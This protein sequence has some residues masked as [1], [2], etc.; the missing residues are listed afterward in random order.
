MGLVIRQSISNSIIS[1]AGVAIGYVNLLYLYP[2]ILEPEQIGTLRTL[3]D[4]ALLFSPFAQFGV[5]QSIQR[6]FPQFGKDT[7]ASGSFISLML[8]MALAG[9]GLFFLAFLACRQ[10]AIAYFEPNAGDFV[11]YLPLTLWLT[12]I[13]VMT[14]VLES[15][16]RALLKTVV[17][18]LLRELVVR[19]LLGVFVL[20]YFNGYLTFDQF[21]LS[22]L[23]AYLICLVSLIIYLL[24]T[25]YFRLSLQ[26]PKLESSL[27]KEMLRYSLFGFAGT[28]G[29]IIIGKV[30][31]LMVAGLMGLAANAVY[32][33]A[34]YM[35]TVIEIPKRALAQVTMPLIARAFETSNMTEIRS[36]Y[37]KTALNQF[38]VGL[39]LLLGVVANLDNFFA[40]MPNGSIYSAGFTV[41][42]IVGAGKLADMFFGPSSEIIVLSRYYAFNIVLLLLLAAMTVALNTYLIPAYGITGAAW[43]AALSLILFNAVKFIFI[44]WKLG[45]QPFSG[46]FI[47]VLSI[48]AVTWGA[49]LLLPRMDHVLFDMAVRSAIMT[50]VFGGIV[51]GLKVSEEVNGVVKKILR[52]K[53]EE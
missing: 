7:K 44:W 5:V 33:T 24:Q 6:Y 32:T 8:T 10:Q 52:M 23:G 50:L 45:L 1:Y 21:I 3:Q 14:S 2:R 38:I 11:Q 13:L 40:L 16:S 12:L 43:S 15:Y 41:V 48:G 29:M 36:L 47:T 20:L 17:P 4:A 27:R 49:S 22:T 19:T 26:W 31:S 30:D 34:F 28:A 42:I 18:N 51:L 37:Q 35:A 25:G 39:L 9:F 46:K 53:N